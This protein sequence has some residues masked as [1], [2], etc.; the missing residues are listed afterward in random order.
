MIKKKQNGKKVWVTFTV[1]PEEGV[2]EVA[3]CGSWSNWAEEPMKL[4]KN[5]EFY[6]T[7]VLP[8]Q[9]TYEFG[10]KIDNDGW[11]AEN[12]CPQTR[13]PFGTQNA[14]LAL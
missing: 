13:S 11:L 6:L 5:G 4:K 1:C 9:S 7:K 3:L 14:V 2:E 8:A 10:Y 12:E